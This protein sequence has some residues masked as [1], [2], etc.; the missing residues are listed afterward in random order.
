MTT[1]KV[2]LIAALAFAESA[3]A[4]P[5]KI[6]RGKYLVE[7]VARCQECHTPKLPDGTFDRA[8]W[9]KGAT[10]NIQPIETVPGWYK[11]SPDITPSGRMWGRWTDAGI[12]NY[13]KNGVGPQGKPAAPPMP[14]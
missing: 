2:F 11:A 9:M 6:E 7:E 3:F 4:Q 13:L 1:S 10:L 5:D 12:L 8:K 14:T